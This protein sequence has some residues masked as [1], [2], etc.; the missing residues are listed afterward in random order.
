MACRTASDCSKRPSVSRKMK[1]RGSSDGRSPAWES[2][3]VGSSGS[4]SPASSSTPSN[5]RAVSPCSGANRNRC[6]LSVRSIKSTKRLQRPHTPSKNRI[7][8]LCSASLWAESFTATR[9]SPGRIRYR[10]GLVT[11]PRS[12][13]R[14]PTGSRRSNRLVPVRAAA[15]V[16][17][18]RPC[19]A[20]WS[21][22]PGGGCR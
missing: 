22:R 13:S 16:R 11:G 6:W 2:L 8:C 3:D 12:C 10:T 9:P 7:G 14:E 15:C 19:A 18:G 20:R 4:S 1:D 5:R 17:A 21:V